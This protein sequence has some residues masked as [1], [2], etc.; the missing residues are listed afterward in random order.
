MGWEE[1]GHPAF[2]SK[3]K[4]GKFKGWDWKDQNKPAPYLSEEKSSN[5]N[6]GKNNGE[7][8]ARW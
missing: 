1:A 5:M 7:L 4:R 8:L 2:Q 3:W 6:G